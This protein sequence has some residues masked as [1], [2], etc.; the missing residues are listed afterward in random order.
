[1]NVTTVI[2]VY[3]VEEYIAKTIDSVIAQDIGFLDNVE[4]ILVND[5]SPDGSGDICRTYAD[6][7]PD[8]IKY[9]EQDN[10][11]VS[12]A[13][14]NGLAHATGKY[15]HFLDSDDM[16]S[17]DA[18]SQAIRCLEADDSVG[19]AT[20]RVE[21]FEG[22]LGDHPLNYKFSSDK[23]VDVNTDPNNP[24]LHMSS[25]IIRREFIDH[26]FD[27][28]IKISEDMKFLT[29]FLMKSPKYALIASAAYYYRKR[30][31]GGSAIDGSRKNRDFYLVTPKKVYEYLFDLWRLPDGSVHPY[32]QYTVAYD[33]QWR[34]RQKSQSVLSSEEESVYKDRIYRLMEQIDDQVFF[35]QRFLSIAQL[36]FILNRKHKKQPKRNM[37]KLNELVDK[38]RIPVRIDFIERDRIGDNIRIEGWLPGG[39][40]LHH[41]SIRVNGSEFEV[42]PSENVHRIESFLGDAI[43]SG[44][45]FY[46]DVPT[47]TLGDVE[48]FDRTGKR[49]GV[50]T[51]RQSGV[52]DKQYGYRVDGDMVYVNQ[53]ES[54][55]FYKKTYLRLV[56]FELR[57]MAR[58]LASL[59]L[60]ES[61]GRL[62]L[63][64]RSTLKSEI[65]LSDFTSPI[66]API[67]MFAKN[68]KHILMRFAYFFIKKILQKPVWVISD[69]FIAAGDN[70][71]ALFDYIYQESPRDISIFF[72][73]DK[74]SPDYSRLKGIYG[75]SVVDSSGLKYRFLFLLSSKVI[76]SHA[77]DL[78][79]NPFGGDADFYYDLFKFDYVFLQHGVIRNDMSSWL[80]RFNK[81]IKLFVVSA[82][83]EYDS[84]L[85]CNYYYTKDKIIL[86]GLPRYDLLESR[87]KSKLVIAPTWRHGLATDPDPVT[88][89]RPYSDSFK[90][91]EY[92][93]FFNSLMNDSRLLRA[94]ESTGMI[95]ELYLHP[96][97]ESQV[98]DFTLSS[99]FSVKDFP[100]DYRT[101]FKEGSIMVTDYSS[102]L[103]DFAYL[104]KPV[105]YAQFDADDFYASQSIYTKGYMDDARD[106]FGPVTGDI[107]STVESIIRYIDSKCSMEDKYAKRVDRFFKWH[108]KG[109]RARIYRAIREL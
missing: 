25:C 91:S 17:K 85:Q 77:D 99:A 2:P 74:S 24:I 4:I 64:M 108:D 47:T 105:V 70:G 19:M 100:Y 41:I 61:A 52:P 106:G 40:E 15:V 29:E 23:V 101:A 13:R 76:S 95:G 10:A 39:S 69:R 8:N 45:P 30:L 58:M 20:L 67:A 59:G 63:I 60:R 53:N 46:V 84:L 37:E 16:I 33:L 54:I 72:A 89:K 96:A 78:V 65:P 93:N 11:G 48:F 38:T 66:V 104:K 98:A 50:V 73:I 56:G 26:E 55:G 82:Q 44:L 80:N 79:I 75:K 83:Q 21:F 68:I 12:A 28:T 109:S 49:V 87:P 62:R 90:E 51:K 94:L 57:W 35:D 14:N 7:Y 5:G 103:F 107:D 92:F 71:E 3:K 27:T 36:S 18:Y 1:M 9:I 86:S 6:R 32:V 43:Y 22:Q 81:N 102:V 31:T 97:F 42:T 34:I 88:G